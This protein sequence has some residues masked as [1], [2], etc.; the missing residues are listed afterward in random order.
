MDKEQLKLALA[1]EAPDFEDV[2]QYQWAISAE[3]D[4]IITNNKK[5]Y[6]F[7]K[8]PVYTS[9]EFIKLMSK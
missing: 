9:N 7:S 5:D 1:F 8:I 6:L 2:L 4:I 3:Y